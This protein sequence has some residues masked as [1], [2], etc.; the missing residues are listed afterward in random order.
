MFRSLISFTRVSSRAHPFMFQ[1]HTFEHEDAE[2][3]G[4]YVAG[5]LRFPEARVVRAQLI[6]ITSHN[7]EGATLGATEAIRSGIR[8][9]ASRSPSGEGQARV[10]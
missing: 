5:K 3:M 7:R 1:G 9:A 10:S 4:Q 8:W 2:M 6:R